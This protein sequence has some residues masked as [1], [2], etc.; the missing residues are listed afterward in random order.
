[1]PQII[2][3]SQS[4]IYSPDLENYMEIVALHHAPFGLDC[5]PPHHRI[6]NCKGRPC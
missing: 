6:E 3:K 5:C 1:M 4:I 2:A